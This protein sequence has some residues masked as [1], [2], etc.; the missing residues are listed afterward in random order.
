[1]PSCLEA[2]QIFVPHE[3]VPS[4]AN[5][6]E[7]ARMKLVHSFHCKGVGDKEVFAQLKNRLANLAA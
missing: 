7:G 3:A 2:R 4:V 5:D 1:M 6:V